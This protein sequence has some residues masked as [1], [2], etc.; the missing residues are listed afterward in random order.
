MGRHVTSPGTPRVPNTR[1]R[2]SR[3]SS[4]ELHDA[5]GSLPAAESFATGSRFDSWW[6]RILATPARKKWWY[7]GG[8]TAVVVIAAV[9]RL[10]NLGNPHSLVFDET[11]YVKDAYSMMHLG[12]EGSWPS[13]ADSDLNA[14][15]ADGFSNTPEF[16]AHPPLGKW[17]IGLGIGLFGI[18]NSA[19][20]RVA[21]AVVGIIAVVVIMFVARSLFSS[22]VL[23]VIAGFLFAIDN[24]AIAMSRVALL[25]NFVMIF[26]LLGFAA[27]LLDRRWAA[28]RLAA[29]LDHRRRLRPDW[30]P[31]WGPTL[32]WRPWLF[33]AAT[34]FGLASGVKWSGL[35]FLLAFIAYVIVVD[36]IA[37]RRGGI[38]FWL[39]A[40]V[41]KQAPAT[42]LAMVPIA[43]MTYVSTWIGWIVTSGGYFRAWANDPAN[44]WSGPLSW[45]PNWVQSLWHYH[46]AMYG[47]NV[48]LEVPHPYQANSLTWLFLIRPT[49]MYYRGSTRGQSGCEFDGCAE[50][51]SSIANPIIWWAA[52]VAVFYLVYRV[53]RYREWRVGFILMGIVAGYV[54]WLLYLHRTVFQ[55][56]CIAFEPY[57]ILALTFV[58]GL[59]LGKR[60]DVSWRR[61]RGIRVVAVY[62]VLVSLVGIFFAA[63]TVGFQTPFWFWQAHVWLPS[64]R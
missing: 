61:V 22:T 9:V 33:V 6:A 34:F 20:W 13:G 1:V 39:S 53:A 58:I 10:W 41:L 27:I 47:Y 59:I 63:S 45:I 30:E 8:P 48:G 18:D 2:R 38:P 51:I 37:R 55:F 26:A 5:A 17:L 36:T 54:P 40:G 49:S 35:F 16:V 23:T 14:G 3:R 64:W 24:Q 7:W 60:T 62:L 56:Y 12:Y 43:L 32:W 4:V 28:V 42:V 31:S 29:W 50:A 19:A 46:V 11:F 57:S 15:H 21:T 52:T 44:S 25:D